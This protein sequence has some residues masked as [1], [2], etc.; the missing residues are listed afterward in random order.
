MFSFPA[1]KMMLILFLFCLF[2]FMTNQA[3]E[4]EI[5]QN[6]KIEDLLQKIPAPTAL[7]RDRLSAEF[8]NLGEKG[9]LALCQKLV[10][11][12][13]IDDSTVRFALHGLS[14]YANRPSAEKDRLLL[15]HSL[16]KGLKAAN[17]TE[18]QSFIMSQLQLVGKDESV[19][20]LSAYLKD[21]KLCEPATQAL[22]TIRTPQA[23]KLLRKALSQSSE[24]N[25]TTIVKALGELQ[26]QPAAKKIMKLA[27]SNND[28]LRNVALFALANIGE[29]NAEELFSRIPVATTAYERTIFLSNYLLLAQRLGE[30]GHKSRAVQICRTILDSY[31]SSFEKNISISALGILANLLGESVLDELL[32]AMDTNNEQL[33]AA[34]LEFAE[35]FPGEEITHRW[36]EKIDHVLPETK[37]RIVAMLGRRGD[38]IAL[39][40]VL[41]SMTDDNQ[42]VRLAAIPAIARLKGDDCVQDL[43]AVSENVSELEMKIIKSALLTLDTDVLIPKVAAALPSATAEAQIAFIQILAERQAKSAAEVV[44]NCLT[45]E[46]DDVRLAAFEALEKLV[47]AYDLPKLVELLQRT[48]NEQEIAAAQKAIAVG[49]CDISDST[50]RKD[51]F[52]AI[53]S[54]IAE[55]KQDG[56]FDALVQIGSAH[57]L[58]LMRQL[59]KN[60][61]AHIQDKAIRS[62]A[63]WRDF[64]AAK[65]L[66]EMAKTSTDAE[67]QSQLLRGYLRLTRQAE[68]PDFQK[69]NFLKQAMASCHA[70]TNKKLVLRGLSDI[71]STESITYISTFLADAELKSFA[72]LMVE[73]MLLPQPESDKKLQS[74]ELIF[75]LKKA[76]QVIDNDFEKKK[77]EEY[78]SH[79]LARHDFVQLFNGVDLTGW[80]GLVENP[81]AR[82]QMNQ[83]ELAFKQ[84]TADSIMRAH[85]NVHDG[86]LIFDGHGESLCTIKDYQDF[87]MLVD[88]K[89]NKEG[90]SGIYLRGSPQVQIWD[91]A[92]WPEGSGGLYNNKTNPS[93]PLVKADNPIGEWNTFRII[94]MGE[95]VTVYL[96]N[97][98]V[99]DNVVMENYWE[100]D[101]SIYPSGQIELQSHHSPLYFRDI[102]LREISERDN[103]TGLSRQEAEDGFEL[104]FNGKNMSG[105]TGDTTG[106]AAQNGKIVLHPEK[107]SGNLYTQQEFAD[108]ILR[109]EFKLTPGANNGLGIRAPLE[110]NAAYEGIELQ[111][112][113]NTHPKYDQLQPYQYHGSIYGVVPAQRGFLKPIGEWNF[114]E[115]IANGT[116]IRVVLN[117]ETILRTN[118][119][120]IDIDHTLDGKEHPGLKRATG[121]IGFLGHGD[122]VEFRRLRLKEL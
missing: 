37:A 89:I 92:Q 11:A 103:F 53:I 114:E 118:L 26:Y 98:L 99:V 34:A 116:E 12:G 24:N 113:E 49:I 20:A 79:L 14:I 111:I 7:E 5:G 117:G 60:Q 90:D 88:W 42:S 104:L 2:S 39:P 38:K 28:N 8:L 10:P 33:Q 16:A 57:G 73:R 43:L 93:K 50:A 41:G 56:L 65:S 15:A 112:L 46:N 45:N 21:Q 1:N 78:L 110:G 71:I 40:V 69:V 62:L 44:W 121:H 115:V 17:E 9:I 6:A 66:L 101:K 13:E 61:P 74:P 4:N 82:S 72:A 76:S 100:R 29:P 68:M 80:K 22:T 77:I 32:R 54:K 102:Y 67:R 95:K 70:L 83:Q 91:P 87:E 84:A 107:S 75:I 30:Q 64:A 52:L 105:W 94:M 48:E 18:V 85:W 58:E 109:F 55:A 122:Q 106:Y 19:R 97:V 47:A 23:K 3:A 35:N 31:A 86:V 96:N 51:S 81:K 36:M 59:S 63:D 27:D 25:L 120:E 119:D 108:F